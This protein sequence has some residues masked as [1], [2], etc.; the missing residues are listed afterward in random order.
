MFTLLNLVHA[1]I[2]VAFVPRFGKADASKRLQGTFRW[3]DAA[4]HGEAAKG[5]DQGF[6]ASVSNY[7]P[8]LTK[9]AGGAGASIQATT[10]PI[11]D[12]G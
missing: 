2:G 1:G 3:L 8:G 10:G 11:W 5:N 6:R 7:F 9:S 4:S 12:S